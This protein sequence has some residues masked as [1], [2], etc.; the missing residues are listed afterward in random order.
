MKGIGRRRMGTL[1]L[2]LAGA[3][4]ASAQW[5]VIDP[6]NLAQN[7]VSALENTQTVL[8]QVTQLS[9]EVESLS[10]QAQNLQSLPASLAQNLL[11]QYTSTFSELVGAMQSL[12]GIA[13]NVAAL[14]ATYNATFPNTAL[15][16]G[17]LSNASIMAQ[18]TTWLAQSR[19]VYAGAYRTQGA[20]MASLAADGGNLQTTLAQSGASHG[21]LD[22]IEAGNQLTGQVAA[23]LMKLNAQ[24][25]ASNEATLTLIS[26]QTQQ[27]AEAQA[28]ATAQA[29]G[30]TT[31]STAIVHPTFDRLH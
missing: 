21:A 28:V 13:Q 4:P 20:V 2:L 9:H 18:L 29:Q 30:F 26:E 23:Q 12:N 27:M 16:Q 31:P 6:S 10:L 7:I 19:S 17:P 22:A 3:V 1:L 8:N 15:G 24:M 14:S 25:A 11:N 5:V